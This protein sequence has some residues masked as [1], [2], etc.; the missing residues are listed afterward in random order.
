MSKKRTEYSYFTEEKLHSRHCRLRTELTEADVAGGPSLD[1]G[2][3]PNTQIF[4][5]I[6]HEAR[7]TFTEN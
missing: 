5:L 4:Q 7:V 2:H 6:A 3:S 1:S